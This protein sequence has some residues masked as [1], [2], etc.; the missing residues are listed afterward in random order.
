MKFELVGLLYVLAIA[1]IA[2]GPVARFTGYGAAEFYII[3]IL[4]LISLGYLA[5]KKVR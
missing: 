2:A 4:G 5:R 3:S 1:A